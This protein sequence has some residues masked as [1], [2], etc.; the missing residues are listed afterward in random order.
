LGWWEVAIGVC[1]L[2]RPLIRVAILLLAFQIPGTFLPLIVL[3]EYCYTKFPFAL[4]IEGQYIIKNLLLIGM[5]HGD[6]WFA[7]A[8]KPARLGENADMRRDG[9]K[10]LLIR[11]YFDGYCG[12]CRNEMAHYQH[13]APQGVFEWL[14]IMREP[15]PALP[16]G[17]AFIAALSVLHVQDAEGV[18]HK[19]FGCFFGYMA[20]FASLPL[21]LSV[22]TLARD[23]FYSVYLLSPVCRLKISLDGVSSL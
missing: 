18:V 7:D 9:D 13:L 20:T 19:G 2:F 11:V 14:D 3:P 5:C 22:F 10:I 15:R 8:I 17:V 1:F 23:L 6:W 21:A 12:V 4:T 16:S